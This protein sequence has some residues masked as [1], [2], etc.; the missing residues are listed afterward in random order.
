MSWWR[1]AWWGRSTNTESVMKILTVYAH[2]E[3]KSFC[4]AVLPTPSVQ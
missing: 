4:H 3:L 2:P 1:L